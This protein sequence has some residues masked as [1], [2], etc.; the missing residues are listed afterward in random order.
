[1][2]AIL[3][4]GTYLEHQ[5]PYYGN[6]GFVSKRLL[7]IIQP[8]CDDTD[9]FGFVSESFGRGELTVKVS[10]MGGGVRHGCVKRGAV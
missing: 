1:M 10:Q 2:V 3:G 9:G 6:E 4:P 7:G 5:K 8:F